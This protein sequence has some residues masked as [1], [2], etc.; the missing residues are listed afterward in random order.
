MHVLA[1]SRIRLLA[2]ARRHVVAS[3]VGARGVRD[4]GATTQIGEEGYVSW[5]GPSVAA[6]LRPRS[7]CGPRA[8]G[9]SP[10]RACR[11]CAATGR[12]SPRSLR[13]A[14]PPP[15]ARGPGSP[16]SSTRRH[17]CGWKVSG[18]AGCRGHR[19]RAGDVRRSRPPAA[20]RAAAAPRAPPAAAPL[21]RRRRARAPLRTGSRLRPCGPP[22]AP[23]PRAQ[24]HTGS[25]ARLRPRRGCPLVCAARRA[26][27]PAT[28]TL[29]SPPARARHRSPRRLRRSPASHATS[30]R[31]ATT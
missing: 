29:V 15:P 21:R 30:A 4:I 11:R 22:P 8:C 31:A 17:S 27:R 28:S 13:C 26:R 16:D 1:S 14:G 5:G 2:S 3:T 19:A 7:G 20:P 18:R 9:G 6:L 24:L 23:S 12:A 25:A 10:I